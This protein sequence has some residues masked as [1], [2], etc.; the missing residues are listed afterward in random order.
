MK[1]AWLLSVKWLGPGAVYICICASF[2]VVALSVKRACQGSR[3]NCCT[4][5]KGNWNL[6]ERWGIQFRGREKG[7]GGDSFRLI[8]I[9]LFL[10][11][12]V[13]LKSWNKQ[14]QKHYPSLC[15]WCMNACT[16]RGC[17]FKSKARLKERRTLSFLPSLLGVLTGHYNP[18]SEKCGPIKQYKRIGAQI[19]LD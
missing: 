17:T 6:T 1:W 14:E 8:S 16:C 4:S 3:I 12:A 9:L 18:A 2:G 13:L 19:P 7:C 5:H 10:C 11:K 15:H